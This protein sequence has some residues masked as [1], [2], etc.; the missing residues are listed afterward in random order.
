MDKYL[1]LLMTFI[2]VT[3]IFV[4]WMYYLSIYMD[5]ITKECKKNSAD[6]RGLFIRIVDINTILK[7]FKSEAK[8]IATSSDVIKILGDTKNKVTKNK[9][10]SSKR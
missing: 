2:T 6:I 3:L 1:I 8:D 9:K 10:K 5:E 7:D 4:F